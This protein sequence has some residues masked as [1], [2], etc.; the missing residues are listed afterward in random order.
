MSLLFLNQWI[1]EAFLKALCWTLIH[2][3]WIGTV[4]AVV[5]GILIGC[6]LRSS[7]LLRYN[8]LVLVFTCFILTTGFLFFRELS[9]F[10]TAPEILTNSVVQQESSRPSSWKPDVFHTP[11]T[12]LFQQ[13]TRY[14]DQHA[15]LIVL[16]WFLVFLVKCMQLFSGL[17]YIHRLRQTAVQQPLEQWTARLV[18]LRNLLGIRQAVTLLESRLTDVPLTIGYVK[19]TILVPIGLLANLPPDQVE[20]IL[21]HEL[22]HIKR[23]DYLV[24]LLQSMAETIFFFNPAIVWISS[25]IRQEREACCDDIVLSH[26]PQKKS[27]LE[28]LVSFQDYSH[29]S[30]YSL[31][32]SESKSG[33]LGRIR[34]MLTKENQKLNSMEKTILVLGIMAITALG[35]LPKKNTE[36]VHSLFPPVAEVKPVPPYPNE[37]P[38]ENAKPAKGKDIAPFV[39]AATE[40]DTVPGSKNKP[41]GKNFSRI[42]SRI[43]DDGKTKV[44]ETEARDAD[45]KTYRILKRNGEI[46]EFTIN[47]EMAEPGEHAEVIQL[48]EKTRMDKEDRDRQEMEKRHM[49][50]QQRKKEQEE[51]HRALLAEQEQLRKEQ[52]VMKEQIR[53]QTSMERKHLEERRLQLRDSIGRL[54]KQR[55]QKQKELTRAH[56]ETN[57]EI[58]AIIADLSDNNLVSD[59]E[60]LS[61]RLDNRELLVNGTRQPA[62]LHQVLKEKYLHG[63]DDLF[64][65]SKKGSSTTITINKE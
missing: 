19:A 60:N 41:D 33:L 57:D 37:S 49:E 31:P 1:P 65:Y 34:R 48:I 6:T 3:L 4:A 47:G 64:D 63:S 35:F 43:H 40:P 15:P 17:Y 32:L 25:R 10:R 59:K 23:R 26:L 51:R 8:L 44:S 62:E 58:Q 5:A 20:S 45:G 13:V 38:A 22:A 24:N 36:T 12:S 56:G 7:A 55:Q 16:V 18:R 42:S 30:A 61:F 28:A 14:F 54:Q 27:Y 39:V 9:Q 11:A 21:L 46:K 50:L 29:G 2:S 53:Q 52:Q